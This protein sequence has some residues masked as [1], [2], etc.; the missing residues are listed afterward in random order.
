MKFKIIV[1]SFFSLICNF[2]TFGQLNPI[3]NLYYQWS[4]EYQ[5]YYCPSFNCFIISWDTPEI[6]NDT[7]IGYNVYKNEKLLIFTTDNV[8]SCEGFYPCPFGDFFSVIPFKITVK[9]VYNQDSLESSVFDEILINDF[10]INVEKINKNE[11]F[12]TKNPILKGE[13]I[14]FFVPNTVTN[15]CSIRIN[16]VKG[17]II[18]EY[19]LKN[20]S[21]NIVN[22]S[23]NKLERGLY[24]IN[25]QVNNKF[26]TF[27]LLI[28]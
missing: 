5:N 8:V 10:A 20:V 27:K 21:N 6:S 13:N 2:K 18:K 24:F 1:F 7:L 4:Y 14:S 19:N 23:S 17:Q 3:N 9:A 15:K 11:V 22:I 25:F 16:S 26:E 28:E 12:I